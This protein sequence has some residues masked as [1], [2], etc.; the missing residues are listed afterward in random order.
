M[1]AALLGIIV[2]ISCCLPSGT[3][4]GVRSED[5]GGVCVEQLL[6]AEDDGT[7]AA[8]DATELAASAVASNC[9]MR[10][11]SP[12]RSVARSSEGAASSHSAARWLRP[13]VRMIPCDASHGCVTGR[14]TRLFEFNL[15]RSSLRA[16]FFLH[17]LCRLRI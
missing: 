8:D 17:S 5:S 7:S 15:Y 16:D 13:G 10:L 11:P 1:Y 14:V 12:C 3:V 9:E 2:W 4:F 6:S